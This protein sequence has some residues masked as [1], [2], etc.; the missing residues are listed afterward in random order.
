MKTT[1][2]YT[3]QDGKTIIDLDPIQQPMS[4][5]FNKF[6]KRLKV[7]DEFSTIIQEMS[8]EELMLFFIKNY[9]WMIDLIYKTNQPNKYYDYTDKFIFYY[10][11]TIM[12][13]DE[14]KSFAKFSGTLDDVDQF[15][16]VLDTNKNRQVLET[17]AHLYFDM[18]ME[19]QQ[20]HDEIN[21]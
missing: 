20:K 5:V 2:S 19:E 8:E 7:G 10:V 16:Y 6:L 12:T 1:L 17:L 15:I 9:V 14:I 13:T 18:M 21:K 4:D 3:S 11:K